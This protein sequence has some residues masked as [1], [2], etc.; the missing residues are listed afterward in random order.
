VG[1]WA[2]TASG[3]AATGVVNA[4]TRVASRTSPACIPASSAVTAVQVR[5]R[6]MTRPMSRSLMRGTAMPMH[7][8]NDCVP[9]PS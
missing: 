6:E 4:G 7:T 2:R 3:P 9:S 8:G 5:A 1:R